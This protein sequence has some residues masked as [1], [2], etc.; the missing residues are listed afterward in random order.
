MI[1]V[2]HALN[3]IEKEI[4]F[5][6]AVEISVENALNHTLAEDVYSPIHMPPFDQS[7][8]DGYAIN[9]SKQ[10][11]YVV[12]DE[13]QAG[14]DSSQITL[15]P[16]EAVRIFTGAMVP[17]SATTVVKQEIVERDGDSIRITEP[18]QEK[19]NIRYEGEQIEKNS[20]ALTKGTTLNV[21]A[22]GYLYMLGITVVKVY[23]KP[24]VTILVTGNELV[25]PGSQL[26]PGK[27][28]ES[29][30]YT[31]QSALQSIGIDAQ[32][33]H[34]KDDFEATKS[35]L[36]TAISNSDLI[37][38]SG[39]ISVG[40]YD[41]VRKSLEEL[42][43]TEVFYK[44]KQKPG[45][46]LYFGKKGSTSIFALPGNPA[47]VLSCFYMY[48]VPGIYKMLGRPNCQLEQRTLSL[49][50]DYKK[51]PKMTHFLKGL[52]QGDHVS[53]LSA[54]SSAMLSSFAEANC[55]VQLDEGDEN[56]SKGDPVK[57][58]MLAD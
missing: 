21:G 47:S 16:G 5:L 26:T 7:A 39:G 25:S 6:D 31:L 23:R 40:D 52:A 13:I 46:P 55:I 36:D 15:Q 4:S 27:I 32:I 41:F 24:I 2:Q 22:V 19:A 33:N 49:Q 50:S 37:L 58:F 18:I 9:D 12:I 30:S 43:V 35:A 44:I 42:G 53:I 34:V 54:Q 28:F 11:K 8:M 1:S 57:V 56:W 29:N 10:N 14:D 51:T 45:K 38:T 48:V 20:I 17:Q 3:Q